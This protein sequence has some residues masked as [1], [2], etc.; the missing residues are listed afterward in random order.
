MT[1][2]PASDLAKNMREAWWGRNLAL[3]IVGIAMAV[4][5]ALYYFVVGAPSPMPIY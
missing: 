4:R 5:A 2:F 3:A 1:Y